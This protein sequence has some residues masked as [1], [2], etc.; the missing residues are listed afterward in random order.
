MSA[1]NTL[2]ANN[3]KYLA[4][5]IFAIGGF[6]I[7]SEYQGKEIVRLKETHSNDMKEIKA[8]KLILEQRLSKKIKV[9]NENSDDIVNLKIDIAI[10]QEQNKKCK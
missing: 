9:M 2:V 1:L 7:Q 6:Y 4:A 10:L 8:E 5:L 3:W